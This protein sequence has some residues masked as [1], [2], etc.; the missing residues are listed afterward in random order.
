M[1]NP[2]V[3]IGELKASQQMEMADIKATEASQENTEAEL[4]FYSVRS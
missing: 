1:E 3:A 2:I 4:K